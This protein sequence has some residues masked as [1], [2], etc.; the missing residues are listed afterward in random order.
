MARSIIKSFACRENCGSQPKKARASG[1]IDS[2]VECGFA[3]G[4]LIGMTAIEREILAALTELEAT[5]KTMPAANP[6]PNLLPLFQRI[7]GLAA[8]LPGST[9]PDLLHYLHKKSYEKARQWLAGQSGEI[10]TG[11][12]LR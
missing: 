6:K 7:E 11:G 2:G 10:Q 8:Q 9:A 5:V 1:A 4:Y 12:C 3:N